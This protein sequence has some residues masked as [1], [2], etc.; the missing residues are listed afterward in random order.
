MK[1]DFKRKSDFLTKVNEGNLRILS[2]FS[3]LKFI[4]YGKFRLII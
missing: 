3:I 1:F 4:A 2:I